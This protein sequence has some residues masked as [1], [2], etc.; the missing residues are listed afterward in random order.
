MVEAAQTSA[1]FIVEQNCYGR[2]T[3]FLDAAVVGRAVMV[4]AMSRGKGQY[5]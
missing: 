1:H 4:P 2:Y 5:V 3:Q